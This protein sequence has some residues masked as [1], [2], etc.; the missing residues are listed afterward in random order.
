MNFYLILFKFQC[1]FFILMKVSLLL[2][3]FIFVKYRSHDWKA[4]HLI[5]FPA[6]EIICSKTLTCAKAKKLQNSLSTSFAH[7]IIL[8]VLVQANYDDDVVHHI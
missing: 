6:N 1:L 7:L 2:K 5:Y 3:Y 4:Q 8:I